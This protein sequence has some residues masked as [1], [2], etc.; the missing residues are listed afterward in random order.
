MVYAEELIETVS[1]IILRFGGG[2]DSLSL[3]PSCTGIKGFKNI[4]EMYR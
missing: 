1:F 3:W 4:L 2:T